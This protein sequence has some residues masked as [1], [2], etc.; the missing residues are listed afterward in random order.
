MITGATKA[1]HLVITLQAL[2]PF[3]G[4]KLPLRGVVASDLFNNWREQHPFRPVSSIVP[5]R[6]ICPGLTQTNAIFSYSSVGPLA[7]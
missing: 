1:L 2:L 4:K 7:P 3:V 6:G 5:I